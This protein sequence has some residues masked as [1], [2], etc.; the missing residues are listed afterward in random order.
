MAHANRDPDSATQPY[1][2][3]HRAGKPNVGTNT[4]P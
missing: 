2:D 4:D 1:R 3:Q